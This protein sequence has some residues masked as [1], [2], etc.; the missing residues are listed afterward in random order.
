MLSILIV[1]IMMVIFFSVVGY[2]RGWQREVIALAGL[3][4]SIALLSQ[5]GFE[6]TNLI[7]AIRVS[8][9]AADP[10]AVLRQQF[11]IQAGVHSLIAFFSYQVVAGLASQVTGGRLGER[12]RAGLESRITGVLFGIVN[13]YLYIGSL[14]GFLEYRLVDAGYERIMPLDIPYAFPTDIITRPGIDTFA[15]TVAGYLPMTVSPTAWLI[16]F[17]VVFFIVIVALI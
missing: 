3:V 11:W 12:L 16:V 7:G 14:W 13:G 8:P 9:E 17:F 15:A 10:N 5:F 2:L 4:A 6:I 1:F